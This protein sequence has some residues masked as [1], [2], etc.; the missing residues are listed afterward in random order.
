MADDNLDAARD[1]LE[2][3][4]E[5]LREKRKTMHPNECPGCGAFRLDGAPPQV[6]ADDCPI[7]GAER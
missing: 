4:K 5:G 7:S 2:D 1:K 6:H 3:L